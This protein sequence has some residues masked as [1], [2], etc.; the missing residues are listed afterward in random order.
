M[1]ASRAV[2]EVSKMTC[3]NC[4]KHVT[5][6]LGRV[7][8]VADPTVDLASGRIELSYDPA[9]VDLATI[10]RAIEDAGYPAKP[11]SG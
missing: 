7:P 11:V 10:A 2:L 1:S 6:A 3:G 9:Q 8:G 5:K 4:V